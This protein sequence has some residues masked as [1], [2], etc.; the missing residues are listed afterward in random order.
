MLWAID[1]LAFYGLA[2][3][4]RKVEFC[5]VF[6]AQGEVVLG[7]NADEYVFCE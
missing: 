5:H 7:L 3:I 1:D 6:S 4:D 2:V